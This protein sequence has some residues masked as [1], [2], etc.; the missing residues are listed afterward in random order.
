MFWQAKPRY[1]EYH[2]AAVE[3]MVNA[4]SLSYLL[5]PYSGE[6]FNSLEYYNRRLRG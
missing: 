1:V 4:L 3:R 6:L 2:R 5:A